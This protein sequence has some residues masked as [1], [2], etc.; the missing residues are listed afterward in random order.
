MPR[1]VQIETWFFGIIHCILCYFRVGVPSSKISLHVNVHFYTD[2][3]LMVKLLGKT[4]IKKA[5]KGV[6]RKGVNP[7]DHLAKQTL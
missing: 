2:K 1:I 7:P 3:E 6:G 5:T 4:H